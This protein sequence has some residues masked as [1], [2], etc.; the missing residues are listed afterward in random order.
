MAGRLKAMVDEARGQQQRVETILRR[1]SDAIIVTD[2]A[3]R[4]SL[5]NLAFERVFD[6]DC[7]A[8]V[9]LRVADA[10]Q[11]SDLD[12]A[13]KRALVG[14][15]ASTETRLL[16]P[17]PRVL[18]ATVAP[19]SEDES[20]GAM[21]LLHDVTRLRRLEA[22]RR[23]FVANASHELQTPITAIRSLAE[24]LLSGAPDGRRQAPTAGE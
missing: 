20:L 12:A 4:I 7:R 2:A 14:I 3:G 18:E 22:V 21:C 5:C 13:F 10:T 17:T 19:I 15:I 1:M 23:E 9:E 6:I 16:F 8:A 11:S 24:A